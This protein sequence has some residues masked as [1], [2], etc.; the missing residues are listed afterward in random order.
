MKKIFKLLAFVFFA[1]ICTISVKAL[2]TPDNCTVTIKE[3]EINSAGFDVNMP[4]CKIDPSRYSMFTARVGYSSYSTAYGSGLEYTETEYG[5]ESDDGKSFKYEKGRVPV[6]NDSKRKVTAHATCT[7]TN[8]TNYLTVACSYLYS[9]TDCENSGCTWTGNVRNGSCSGDYNYCPNG[10]SWDASGSKCIQSIPYTINKEVSGDISNA[11]RDCKN[12]TGAQYCKCDAVKYNL[13]CP[14]YECKQTNVNINACTPEFRDGDN[15]VYC[16]NPSQPFNGLYAEDN[17]FNVREC[18]NS[19]ITPDC[20]FANILIE[21]AFHENTNNDAINLALRLWSY[22]TNFGGFDDDRKTGIAN[23]SGENCDVATYFMATETNGKGELVRPNVY[24]NTYDYIMKTNKN[25]YFEVAQKIINDND[26]LPSYLTNPA[27]NHGRFNG[28]TFAKI[29]CLNNN[30]SVDAGKIGV[31]CGESTTYR[32][33]FELFFNTML[34]NKYMIDH[35]DSLYEGEEKVI[36]STGA[37]VIEEDGNA[38]VLVE[39]NTVDFEKVFKDAEEIPCDKN[40]PKYKKEIEPYC[41]AKVTYFDKNGNQIGEAEQAL[42]KCSKKDNGCMV[43]TTYVARCSESEQKQVITE[44]WVKEK[45]PESGTSIRKLIPCGVTSANQFMFEYIEHNTPGSK[46]ERTDVTTKYYPGYMC[47]EGCHKY[48]ATI[49]KNEN[50]STEMNKSYS[51]TVADPSL[52]CIV[53]MENPERKNYYDYSKEFGVN[54]NFC[55]IYCSDEAEYHIAGRTEAQAGRYFVYDVRG[56][57]SNPTNGG[58]L[59]DHK[60]NSVIKQ[61]RTCVSEIF[62]DS[63]PKTTNWKKLYGLTNAENNELM[64]NATWSNLYTIMANKA[65]KERNRKENLNQLVYDLYNCNLYDLTNNKMDDIGIWKPGNYKKAYAKKLIEDAFGK[66]NNYGIADKSKNSDVLSFEG[67]AKVAEYYDS[68]DGT[69]LGTLGKDTYKVN[70]ESVINGYGFTKKNGLFIK[71]C[72]FNESKCLQYTDSANDYKYDGFVYDSDIRD[73]E[74]INRIK[75]TYPINRYALFEVTAE[76]GFYNKDI[77]QTFENTGNITIGTEYKDMLTL[78]PYVYP[79]DK[80]SHNECNG[81]CKVTQTI[82][83]SPFFRA[84]ENDS[85]QQAIKS[86]DFTCSVKVDPAIKEGVDKKYRIA[87]PADLFPYELSENSN[88]NTEIGK[89]AREEIEGNASKIGTSD[90][91]IDYSITLTPE[92]IKSVKEYNKDASGN[93]ISEKIYCKE[94]NIDKTSSDKYLDCT[95]Q[96]LNELRKGDSYGTLSIDNK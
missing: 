15:Y 89:K 36:S 7:A 67:G 79:L 91:L 25:N 14:M 65:G 32:V 96:Y 31:V 69:I 6:C 47:S 3:K 49:N 66:G 9:K 62:I 73:T 48:D 12:A 1:F 44:I 88:W 83:I 10:F 21:A 18:S 24:K 22:H 37:N 90:D 52:S 54:T 29:S 84:K 40:N 75:Y 87:D 59:L 80:Y 82:G 34:G 55:R 13:E 70:S 4:I 20:G 30:G 27:I 72:P 86:M 45:K 19:Y 77:Y 53:N 42:E 2:I 35:L 39:Y 85:Y 58:K 28:S 56:D 71:Y 63:L 43:R 94:E 46:D 50:C 78:K 38:W 8:E 74:F 17:D 81:E 61:K 23:R 26:Y 41:K 57:I 11:A 51:S 68:N 33:A 16:V 95:S 93:Y 5:L 64:A 92:Q 60:L 76:I